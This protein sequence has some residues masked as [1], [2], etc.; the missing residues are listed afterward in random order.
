[1]LPRLILPFIAIAAS[2]S[3]AK[4]EPVAIPLAATSSVPAASKQAKPLPSG[5]APSSPSPPV[6]SA[7]APHGSHANLSGI[8]V[9][10]VTFDSRTHQLKVADQPVG[11]G[12]TWADA[13]AA[14]VS[15]D[16]IAAVNGGFFTPEG[17]PLGLV[18][19][20]GKRSGA[21]NRASSLG[22]GFY[23]GGITPSLRRRE[24]WSAGAA[25]ALQSGPFLIERGKAVAGLSDVSSTARTIIGWDG[26][27]RWFLARTGRCSLASLSAALQGSSPG[28]VRAAFV[29]NLD[30]G[31]SSDLWI[32]SS[33][34]GG[35]VTERPLWNKPVRN[36]L[37]LQPRS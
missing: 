35:P 6:A 30:G 25:E 29:L 22:A 7:K 4:R 5:R 34:Q 36:F 17:G 19:S 11:P 10:L 14:A 12:S 28:G 18:V 20:D 26:G 23:E 9:T 1:M 21:M 32:S 3:P 31:R 24:G 27:T 13:Q 37:V 16:G 2:C 8:P 15:M 33:V